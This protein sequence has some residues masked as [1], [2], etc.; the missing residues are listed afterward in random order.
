MADTLTDLQFD[1]LQIYFDSV[2]KTWKS[3][4]SK[5][6]AVGKCR[7]HIPGWAWWKLTYMVIQLKH[8][9]WGGGKKVL[10]KPFLH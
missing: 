6:L 4:S 1:T 9:Y 5:I 7:T 3:F 8:Y 2:A 10:E